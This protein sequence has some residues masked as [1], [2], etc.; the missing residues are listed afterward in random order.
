MV[1]KKRILIIKFAKYI[2]FM[3]YLLLT[4]LL[5]KEKMVNKSEKKKCVIGGLIM[6]D[7]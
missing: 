6:S 4:N 1:N 3:R 5:K 7:T 2:V